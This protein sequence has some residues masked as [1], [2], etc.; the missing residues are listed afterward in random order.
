MP[1]P[2]IEF[3]VNQLRETL[4]VNMVIIDEYY[5]TSFL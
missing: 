5:C 2:Y 4:Q 1:Y 3:L